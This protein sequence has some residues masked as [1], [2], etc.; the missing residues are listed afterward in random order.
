[1]F[2]GANAAYAEASGAWAEA[3]AP[4][5]EAS[6]PFAEAFTAFAAEYA[7]FAEAFAA[8]AAEY[9]AFAEAYAAYSAE[10][11]WKTGGPRRATRQCGA[12]GRAS[13]GRRSVAAGRFMRR[14]QGGRPRVLL[15][16]RGSAAT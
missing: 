5:A 10:Y 3:L 11:P 7:A 9:A 14:P 2:A 12:E 1:M 16:S 13:C 4:F 15:S 6:A 8:F